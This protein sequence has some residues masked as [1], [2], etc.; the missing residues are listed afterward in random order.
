M[1]VAFK[2]DT[3]PSRHIANCAGGK[4]SCGAHFAELDHAAGRP[5]AAKAHEDEELQLAHVA[6]TRVKDRLVLVSPACRTVALSLHERKPDAR[7]L[8]LYNT[9]KFKK[10]R[11]MYDHSAQSSLSELRAEPPSEARVSRALST[12]ALR[13]AKEGFRSRCGGAFSSPPPEPAS[14]AACEEHAG[15]RTRGGGGG[16]M[17]GRCE[18]ERRD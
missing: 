10:L 12:P 7:V 9:S 3:L 14:I 2:E 4:C 8:V 15:P 18:K 17:G 11:Y 16:V 13:R 5:S 6:V 1:P